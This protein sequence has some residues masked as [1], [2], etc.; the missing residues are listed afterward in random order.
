LI[1]MIGISG[2]AVATLTTMTLNAILARRVIAQN[3]ELR[4]ERSS[5]QNILKASII[6]GMIVGMYRL[7]VPL[8][9]VWLVLVPVVL[10]GAVYGFL[11]FKDRKIYEELK[12]IKTQMNVTWPRLL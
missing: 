3:I 11:I 9:N 6:M 2:A 7:I 8:S 4:V 10:G 1:P 12:E 5:L